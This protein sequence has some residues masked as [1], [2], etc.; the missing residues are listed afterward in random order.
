MSS[1][2]QKNKDDKDEKEKENKEN[3]ENKEKENKENDSNICQTCLY[4]SVGCG[5]CSTGFICC[6]IFACISLCLGVGKTIVGCVT[7]DCSETFFTP[8]E[9]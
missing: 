3:K 7:C 9:I 5:K 1:D 8:L 2:S 4:R 6:P